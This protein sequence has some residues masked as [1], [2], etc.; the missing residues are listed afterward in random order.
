MFYHIMIVCADILCRVREFQRTV[1]M[2]DVAD[3]EMSVEFS[4]PTS[5]EMYIYRLRLSFD[6]YRYEL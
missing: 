6:Y 4:T 2:R 1:S 3:V 5:S